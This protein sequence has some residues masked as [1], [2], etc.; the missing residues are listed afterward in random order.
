MDDDVRENWDDFRRCGGVDNLRPIKH[1][2]QI[3]FVIEEFYKSYDFPQSILET[4][5]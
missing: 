1:L 3:C 4:I 2:D 5:I